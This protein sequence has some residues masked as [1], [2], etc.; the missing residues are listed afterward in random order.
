[1]YHQKKT[2]KNQNINTNNK[3]NNPLFQTNNQTT[4]QNKNPHPTTTYFKTTP[5]TYQHPAK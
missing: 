4:T 5:K 2:H 3:H 1:M